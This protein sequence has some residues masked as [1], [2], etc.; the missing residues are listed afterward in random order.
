MH[1]ATYCP[2]DNKLRLYVGRVPRPDYE[3]LRAAGYTSTPKQECDFVATWTPQ[4]ED[5]ARE[6]LEDGE[7]IGDEDYSPEER[8]ADR[9]ERFGDYRDKRAAE[10]GAGADRF[11]AGPSAFG[12]QNRARAERQA[13]RHDRK[14]VYA[15]SQWA[16]A[17]Y[18]QTRTAAVISHRLYLASASVRRGRILRLEAEQRRY[19]GMCDRWKAHYALRLTY[20]RAML[21]AEG[22]TAAAVDIEPGGWFGRHQVQKVNRSTA[23]GRVVSVGVIGPHPWRKA[24]DGSPLVGVQVLNI[25]RM[26]EDAYRAPTEEERAAFAAAKAQ[27]KAEATP[28]PI[29]NPTPEDAQRLQTLWNARAEERK[30]E[31]RA[32]G[33]HC[34]TSAPSQVEE[35]TQRGF[36][37]RNR[38]DCGCAV[39]MV[40][41]AGIITGETDKAAYRLRVRR[42]YGAYDSASCVVILTDKPQKPLP[43]LVSVEPANGELFAEVLA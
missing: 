15:V 39:V 29:L 20:E 23:T 11:D 35:M 6:F 22:G 26:G 40:T 42:R 12:H 2:E 21:E 41:S 34:T 3:R 9:A 32:K 17:E 28:L 16:K 10:A 36:S 18:W 33:Q 7:D 1:T 31:R 13:L 19:S 8:S 5:L 4:R 38:D 37:H 30:A 43:A 27:K 25:E 14:R 24:A